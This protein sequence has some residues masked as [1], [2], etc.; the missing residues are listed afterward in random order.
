MIHILLI[1][2]ILPSFC[3]YKIEKELKIYG[4]ISTSLAAL[5]TRIPTDAEIEYVETVVTE[6][7]NK[8]PLLFIE[9]IVTYFKID[10]KAWESVEGRYY[11]KMD[12]LRVEIPFLL[13]TW[14]QIYERK[15]DFCTLNAETMIVLESFQG[16]YVAYIDILIECIK[17]SGQYGESF[18][19]LIGF[20]VHLKD[21]ETDSFQF[22]LELQHF[23]ICHT[24]FF[25]VA[26]VLEEIRGCMAFFLNKM[27]VRGSPCKNHGITDNLLRDDPLYLFHLKV[28]NNNI[29]LVLR[30][31]DNILGTNADFLSW[32]AGI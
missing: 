30:I 3:V 20:L 18:N 31:S 24:Y 1:V 27:P 22:K 25:T 6:L 10:N 2:Q 4:K 21:I 5:S 15:D 26:S 13:R 23:I 17:S 12:F 11:Y 16:V 9:H 14:E 7:R 32:V 29:C 19:P 28:W 8:L